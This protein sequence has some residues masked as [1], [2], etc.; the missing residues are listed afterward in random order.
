M[1]IVIL[2]IGLVIMVNRQDGDYYV[3]VFIR[4]LMIIMTAMGLS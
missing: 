4:D 1:I 3:I 2:F